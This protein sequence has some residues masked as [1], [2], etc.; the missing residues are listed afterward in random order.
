M[1]WKPTWVLL[2]AAA[3]VF[4]FI[5]LVEM[6]L[7]RERELRGNRVI[8]PG[9]DPSLVTNIE[10]RPWGRPLIKA[11]RPGAGHSWRLTQPISYPAQNERVAALLEVLEK[12]EWIER[13]GERELTNRPNAQEE[14]G[15]NKPRVTL[16]LQ[17]SGSDRRLEIGALGA[18]GDRVFLQVVGNTAIY[19]SPADILRLTPADKN[20]WRDRALLNLTNLAFQT[21]RVSAAGK[22]LFDLERDA[23]N[24][25]WF[26][27]KP[28]KARADT[29]KINGLLSQLQAVL[30][31]GFVIDDPRADLD[32]YGLAASDTT[33]ELAL[34]FLDYTNTVAGLQAG[35]SPTNHPGL[36]F[37]RR[38]DPGNVVVIPKESLRAWQAPST[39][40]LDQHFVS[41]SPSLIDSITVRGGDEFVARKQ[42]NG[43]WQV[44]GG[45]G[46]PADAPLMGYWL[47]SFTNVPT[48]IVK[49]VVTDY[50]PYGLDPPCLQYI[51]RFGAEAGS[52][53]EARIDFG[54]NHAGKVFERR[55]GED[56][57]NTINPGDF[58]RFPRVSWQLR[59]RQIWRFGSSN[60]LSVTIHQLGGMVKYLRDPDGNW[61]YAP[62]FNSQIAINS[63]ALEEC[64]VRL[65]QLR[66]VY[67]DGVGDEHLERFG[68]PQA[69]F[70]VDLEVKAEAV[71]QLF[72][73]RFG[74]RSPYLHPYASIVRDG[75]RLIFEFP[76]DL[77][78]SFV[79]PNL[80]VY[81]ARL[82]PR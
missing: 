24:H 29:P 41:L 79:L 65:G 80:T 11:V 68:F 9:L 23:T 17:G 77:Y 31:S 75:E 42:T 55:L 22:P 21:L 4:A 44:V 16:L 40:F 12:L 74:G 47:A 51:V 73:I 28:L 59:D 72:R 5:A 60:V 63:P 27:R 71:N 45:K 48:E 19:E 26:M 7:L 1:N 52:Q 14:F 39:N 8:L 76:A 67:W 2:A 82:R 78:E 18:F 53:A 64:V 54:T 66:A 25:L 34:S 30:V 32:A 62:G 6:P 36:V 61:T 13:I 10:I 50:S 33:P 3:V 69:D 49:T 57:V 46:F 35:L 58:G 38:D 20:Q 37:V 81:E 43:Q 15:F 70:T 56:F